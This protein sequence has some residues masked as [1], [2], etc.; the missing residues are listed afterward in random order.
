MGRIGDLLRRGPPIRTEGRRIMAR[1]Q[2]LGVLALVAGIAP[3]QRPAPETQ[4]IRL[5]ANQNAGPDRLYL[6]I[7]DH[8]AYIEW[9][10][11]RNQDAAIYFGAFSPCVEGPEI[12]VLRGHGLCSLKP[13]LCTAVNASNGR[14]DFRYRTP[15]GESAI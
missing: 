6:K 11:D 13:G 3:A 4:T 7:G 15:G 2:L 10:Q 5:R 9:K 8:T 14:C 12:R 1:R